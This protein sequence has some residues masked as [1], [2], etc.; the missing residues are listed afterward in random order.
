[1]Y[2]KLN[3]LLYTDDTGFFAE[4]QEDLQSALNDLYAYCDIWKLKVSSAKT[5]VDIF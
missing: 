3:L 4:S 1:M 2:L 5:K